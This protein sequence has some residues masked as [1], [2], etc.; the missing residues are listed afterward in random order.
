[1]SSEPNTPMGQGAAIEVA[2]VAKCY[3]IYA[4][5]QDRLRQAL[6]PEQE[7]QLL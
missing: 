7:K 6:L 2:D 3:Q 4:N 5:P 1:M